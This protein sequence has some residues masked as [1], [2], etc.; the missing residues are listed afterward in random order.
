MSQDS[1]YEISKF[2]PF[3]DAQ[4]CRRVKSIPRDQI[5]SNDSGN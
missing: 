4:L 1:P 5:T 2:F 3:H